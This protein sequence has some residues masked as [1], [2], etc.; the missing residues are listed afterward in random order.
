M[1]ATTVQRRGGV[2]LDDRQVDRL[3]AVDQGVAVVDVGGVGDG[4]DVA[5]V[6]VAAQ[7]ERNLAELLDVDDHGIV[8]H[9]RHL[10]P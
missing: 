7:L 8:R 5:D 3:A 2:L 6:D 4:G 10:S 9:Q 1:S